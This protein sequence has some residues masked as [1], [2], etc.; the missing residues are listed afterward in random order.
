MDAHRM[1][2]AAYAEALPIEAIDRA[3]HDAGGFKMAA[4][5]LA[6]EWLAMQCRP[7]AW[8]EK[9]ADGA[10]ASIGAV[11]RRRLDERRAAR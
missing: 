5:M 7:R 1:T 9:Y 10:E 2:A 6:A 11:M 4:G 8:R 3:I